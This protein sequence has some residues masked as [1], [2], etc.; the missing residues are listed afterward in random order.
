[1]SAAGIPQCGSSISKRRGA[2]GR[3]AWMME[4]VSKGWDQI[5]NVRKEIKD[6]QNSY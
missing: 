5:L 2:D 6:A 3:R 1:M 4:E